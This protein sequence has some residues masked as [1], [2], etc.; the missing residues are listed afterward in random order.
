MLVGPWTSGV[1]GKSK[2]ENGWFTED[3]VLWPGQRFALEVEEV[4]FEGRSEF[5][6]VLVFQ[7][8]TYG[9]VLVLD[10]VIQ[11]TERDE[12]AYQEMMTHVPLFSHPCPKRVLIIGGGDGGVLREVCRH[13]CVES[14]TMCELDSMVCNK[15]KEFLKTVSTSFDDPR[16]TLLHADGAAFM[17][18]SKGWDVIIVDSSDPVGPAETL[19]ESSFYGKCQRA[20]EPHNGILCVQG[21]CI[22]LHLELIS[23]VMKNL[24]SIFSSVEYGY[25]TIP[26]YPSGQIGFI[27]AGNSRN[28]IFRS[29]TRLADPDM[30][31]SLRYYSPD[32]HAASF[33]LPKFAEEKIGPFRRQVTPKTLELGLVLAVCAALGAGIGFALGRR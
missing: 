9:R 18:S 17:E 3:E 15:S 25:L 26:T 8:K 5:Q 29:P 1:M 16:V 27:L 21:E 23:N 19:F 24:N 13:S 2:I 30:S 12:Y 7:S 28:V 22:W 14:I 11:L 31:R 6:D 32:I 33:V 4:L 10:G 20:L